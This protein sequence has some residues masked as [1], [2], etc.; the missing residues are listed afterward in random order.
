MKMK[1]FNDMNEQEGGLCRKLAYTNWQKE[2]NVASK[3]KL[4]KKQKVGISYNS[5]MSTMEEME[6]QD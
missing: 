6:S 4:L 5:H 2:L 3:K 1:G